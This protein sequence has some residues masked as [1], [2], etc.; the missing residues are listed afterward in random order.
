MDETRERFNA[1]IGDVAS[2]A[3]LVEAVAQMIA[4]GL[5]GTTQFLA[6]LIITNQFDRVCTV[7]RDLVPYRV[8][9]GELRTQLLDWLTAARNA[10]QDRNRVVHAS[11]GPSGD[12]DSFYRV[13]NKYAKGAMQTYTAEDVTAI[14]ARLR[15][16]AVPPFLAELAS[17]TGGDWPFY[18]GPP[19]AGIK[20]GG[21]YDENGRYLAEIYVGAEPGDPDLE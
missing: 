5:S 4:G 7:I 21:P 6:R 8:P 14:A 15:D 11:W 17:S 12:T 18:D 2:S 13:P 16:L 3:S 20:Y 19:W 1:A 9:E 10:Y